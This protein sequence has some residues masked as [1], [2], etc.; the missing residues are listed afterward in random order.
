[1]LIKKL[2]KEKVWDTPLTD[3]KDLTEQQPMLWQA[4]V[5]KEMVETKPKQ[6]T[7]NNRIKCTKLHQI[8]SVKPTITWVRTTIDP[9]S[10][11]PP[12]NTTWTVMRVATKRVSTNSNNRRCYSNRW[13]SS[14]RWRSS[15][16]FFPLR[17]TRRPKMPRDSSYRL[18]RSKMETEKKWVIF[19][20]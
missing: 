4:L 18:N 5:V 13:C 11:V 17:T 8:D 19:N 20:K 7:L 3:L 15:R 16:S 6:P 10:N 1:M 14:T 2:R 12:T 9:L